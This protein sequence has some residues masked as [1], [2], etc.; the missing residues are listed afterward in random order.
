MNGGQLKACPA[1]LV[2]L[3]AMFAI[4]LAPLTASGQV[5][6]Y[7]KE[8][9]RQEIKQPTTKGYP[10]TLLPSPE[11]PKASET[12]MALLA[13]TPRPMMVFDPPTDEPIVAMVDNTRYLTRS[14]LN[15]K[16]N[17]IIVMTEK[18]APWQDE[19]ED[20][21]SIK[22]TDREKAIARTEEMV[23][24]D[25]VDRSILT[26]QAVA[27]NITVTPL[28]LEQ[29]LQEVYA[30][31][32]HI[33]S[34][35]L[36]SSAVN[37]VIALGISEDEMKEYVRDAVLIEKLV[38]AQ[39]S[40]CSESDLRQ[41]YDYNRHIFITSDRM[42]I[43]CLSMVFEENT[44]LNDRREL[45]KEMDAWRKKAA[46]AVKKGKKP[47]DKIK[48]FLEVAEEFD[49]RPMGRRGGNMGWVTASSLPRDAEKGS[50]RILK[51]I[52]KLKP[53]EVTKVLMGT[54]GFYVFQYV[55][56]QQAKG[57]TYESVRD[58]VE[59]VAYE[60]MREKLLAEL[61][62]RHTIVIRQ[63][64]SGIDF[65]KL[66]EYA[67]TSETDRNIDYMS[68]RQYQIERTQAIQEAIRDGKKRM[69]DKAIQPKKEFSPEIS[70]ASLSI[71]HQLPDPP[72]AETIEIAPATPEQNTEPAIPEKIE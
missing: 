5:T 34:V 28:E 23:I 50:G 45:E 63:S 68:R 19:P 1:R 17:R 12:P 62:P 49:N 70:P 22:A 52:Q 16:V 2:F 64:E 69:Y 51:A 3:V 26:T 57:F 38:Q 6:P 61:K 31:E 39:M 35:G 21:E 56:F 37:A 25:W 72:K 30:A 44:A 67:A 27:E 8:P 43:N 40:T 60:K 10:K 42:R 4:V 32:Q 55:E 53:G 15:S 46:K 13:P 7:S 14:Q 11:L 59:S 9:I 71:L 20:G 54:V 33:A 29:K 48:R 65:E 36:N 66:R 18:V 24:A 47:L 41:I 58:Q